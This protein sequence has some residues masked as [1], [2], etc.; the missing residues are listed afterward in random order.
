MPAG[1]TDDRIAEFADIMPTLLDLAG[2]DIPDT[3]DRLSLASTEKRDYLYGEHG[4]G[5]AAMRMIRQGPHKLIYYPVGN[6][7]QLFDIGC[8]PQECR[9]LAGDPGHANVLE[10]LTG[11]LVENLYGEDLGWLENGKLVGRPAI[12]YVPSPSRD[13]RNQR[14]LRFL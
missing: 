12:D 9:D 2:L 1:A 14:G 10:R 6:Q 3:V 11:V 5:D 7:R 8:D 4:E 13:L